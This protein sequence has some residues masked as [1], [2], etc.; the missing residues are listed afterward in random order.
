LAPEVAA[1]CEPNFDIE[2]QALAQRREEAAIAHK[3]NLALLEQV[4]D[5]AKK[6]PLAAAGRIL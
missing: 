4:P 3:E 2:I 6:V 5:Q 1:K